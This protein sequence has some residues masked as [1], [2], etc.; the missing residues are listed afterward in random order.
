MTVAD[1]KTRRTAVEAKIAALADDG[2]DLPNSGGGGVN[3]DFV[4][5][6]KSLYDELDFLNRQIAQRSPGIVSTTYTP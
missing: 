3:P 4:G 6:K 2:L 1:L 5:Y